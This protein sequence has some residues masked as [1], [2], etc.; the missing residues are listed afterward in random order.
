MKINAKPD[1]I[2]TQKAR[3]LNINSPV[4]TYPLETPGDP[5]TTDVWCWLHLRL[6]GLAEATDFEPDPADAEPDR[7]NKSR[8]RKWMLDNGTLKT[9]RG[10]RV[11]EHVLGTGKRIQIWRGSEMEAAGAKFHEFMGDRDLA[12]AQ[13]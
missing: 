2:K 9:I 4:Q 11:Y 5:P 7:W 10:V 8:I 6:T 12:G 3:V 1:N 13:F